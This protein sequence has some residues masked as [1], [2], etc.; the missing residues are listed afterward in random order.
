M[1]SCCFCVERVLPAM[2]DKL[3]GLGPLLREPEAQTL[4]DSEQCQLGGRQPPGEIADGCS[5]PV[6]DGHAMSSCE[7]QLT[8]GWAVTETTSLS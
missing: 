5:C 1:A 7:C 3:M 8:S 4:S 2:G 6:C